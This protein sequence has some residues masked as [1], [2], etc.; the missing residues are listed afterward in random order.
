MIIPATHTEVEQLFLAAEFASSRSICITACQS[1]DGVTSTATAL[2]ERYLLAGYKTLLVD[3]NTLHPAFET[4]LE[5]SSRSDQAQ[6]QLIQHNQTHQLFT[7]FVIPTTQAHILGCKDPR[8]MKQLTQDWLSE[9]DRIVFDTS[10]LLHLN[11]QSIPAQVIA[12]AC[13]QTVLV[14]MSSKNTTGQ[15]E[16]AVQLLNSQQIT[17]LGSV[18]NLQ[19]HATLGQELARQLERCRFIPSTWRRQWAGRLISSPFLS[20][21]A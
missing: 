9:F 16:K 15:L 13:D 2:T 3:M 6:T 17:L 5:I 19:H 20:Q 1:G 7:G 4:T 8:Q 12:S 14:V 11:R 18:V 21:P 10:P